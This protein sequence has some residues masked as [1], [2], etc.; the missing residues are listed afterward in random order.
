MPIDLAAMENSIVD[1]EPETESEPAEGEAEPAGD[2]EA[3][4]EPAEGDEPAEAE[5]ETVDDSAAVRVGDKT[6]TV[7]E[8]KDGHLMQAD[9]SRKTQA[10]ADERAAFEQE[11]DGLHEENEELKSWVASLS[12]PAEMEFELERYFPDQFETLRQRIIEQAIEEQEM[13]DR[14]R[15]AHRRARKAEVAQKAREKDEAFEAKKRER[16]E[17]VQRTAALR[18]TFNGWLEETMAASGLD[19]ANP[20]HQKL[21]RQEIANEHRGKTW[22]KETFEAATKEVASVLG[23]KPKAPPG[24]KAELPPVRPGG[25]KAPADKAK[26]AKKKTQDSE[27]FFDSLRSGRA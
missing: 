14:E 4:A 19:P 20:K 9:Y 6:L 2:A 15:D 21:V 23:A 1:D 22:T 25:V 11:R 13:T 10:L 12:D 27:N 17:S 18:Q 16:R 5:P 26:P 7:K 24:K 8:L 3:P